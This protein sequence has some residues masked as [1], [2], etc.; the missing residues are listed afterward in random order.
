MP[1]RMIVANWKMH[2]TWDEG[3]TWFQEL[4]QHLAQNVQKDL[5]LILCP[6]FIHL[7]A[8]YR[9]INASLLNRIYLGAQNCH[10][11]EKGAFTGEVSAAM[12][13]SVGT[14]YVLIGHSER[15]QYFQ[16]D[17]PL[18]A[19]K[20]NSVL[21][22]EMQPIC[23]CG[24]DWPTR[25][26]GRHVSWVTQQ[27]T[28]SLFHL[29]PTQISQVIIAYEPVWAIGSGRIPS[30]LEIEEMHQAIREHL[31]QQYGRSIAKEIPILYG[32]SCNPVNAA[33]LLS[34]PMIAGLL[35]GGA[36]LQA[37]TFLPII[38]AITNQQ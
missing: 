3:I 26:E 33:L 30:L 14:R 8:I 35:V 15:R 1:A 7:E 37:D 24:E 2:K 6:S 4:N 23:C 19:K 32:G 18:L 16:E 12:L 11:E 36:S 5:T 17:A 21:L 9:L 29:S 20:V 22:H 25:Q 28:E 34:H 38:H 13:R 27:L 31:S 10:Q